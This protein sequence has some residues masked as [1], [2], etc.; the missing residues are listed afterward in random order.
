MLDPVRARLLA[1]LRVEPG[2]AAMLAPRAGTTRQKARH[3]LRL[4]ERHGL[5]SPAGQRR[6]GGLV[7]QLFAATAAGYVVSPAWAPRSPQVAAR[8][9]HQ[10]R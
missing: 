6:H 10:G 8:Q 7:E 2:S 4:L 9:R 3:N 1:E 5:V